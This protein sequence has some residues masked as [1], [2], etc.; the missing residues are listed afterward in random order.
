MFEIAPAIPGSLAKLLRLQQLQAEH[1]RKRADKASTY[2]AVGLNG[3]RAVARR[4]KQISEGRLRPSD[5][6]QRSA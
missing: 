4:L 1:K 5:L 3:R 6:P 2:Q